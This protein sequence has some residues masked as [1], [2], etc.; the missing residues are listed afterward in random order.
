MKTIVACGVATYM[1]AATSWAADMPTFGP[2]EI[3]MD[4]RDN[5]TAADQKYNRWF[6]LS[7]VVQA[8]RIDAWKKMWLEIRD[9]DDKVASDYVAAEVRSDQREAI[10][11]YRRWDEILLVCHGTHG[12][13][14]AGNSSVALVNN[15]SLATPP[16]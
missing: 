3:N 4:Y 6:L 2:G 10:A 12:S 7:G 5:M 16:R 15:C 9:P 1:L 13:Q 14:S 8:H 11:K